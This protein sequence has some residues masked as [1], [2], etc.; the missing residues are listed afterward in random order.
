MQVQVIQPNHW[1]QPTKY[2]TL[3]AVESAGVIVP[4]GF[5]TDGATVS[6]WFAIA[7]LVI[8]AVAHFTIQWLYL[9]GLIGILTP[10]LFPRVGKYFQAAVIHDYLLESQPNRKYA[11]QKFKQSLTEHKIPNWQIALMYSAVRVYGILKR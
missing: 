7:G 1:W 9:I 8:V 6:R 10:A 3:E 5:I 4:V 11:D 2:K